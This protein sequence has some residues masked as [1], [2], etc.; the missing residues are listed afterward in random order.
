MSMISACNTA[1]QIL[2]IEERQHWI[3]TS[4]TMDEVR[5]YDSCFNGRLSPTAELQMVQLYQPA[6]TPTGLVVTVIPIQQQ[7][8]QNNC[9]VFSIAAAFHAAAGG[10]LGSLSFDER[11]M[12]PH[13][14]QCFEE[15]KIAPFPLSPSSP[16]K[17]AN[18]QN[19]VIPVNCQCR[20]PDSW[21]QMVACDS[22]DNWFHF[23]CANIEDAPLGFFISLVS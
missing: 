9:G 13:L 19:I 1:V 11:R 15:G 23:S 7:S 4:Y 18:A 10:D 17:R 5:L 2:F 12:R 8:Q 21:E 6:L 22:C 3:A 14:I 20:R 16:K